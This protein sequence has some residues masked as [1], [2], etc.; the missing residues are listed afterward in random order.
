MYGL[1]GRLVSPE[2]SVQYRTKASIEGGGY[3]SDGNT[4]NRIYDRTVAQVQK[5]KEGGE[6]R[7]TRFEGG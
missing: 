6:R 7:G 3:C 1:I 5:E 4:A 2:V